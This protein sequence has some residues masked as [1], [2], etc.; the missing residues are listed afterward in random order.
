MKCPSCVEHQ[1]LHKGPNLI[2]AANGRGSVTIPISLV[3]MMRTHETK[4]AKPQTHS[5]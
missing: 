1:N 2:L 3:T 4:V 5:T